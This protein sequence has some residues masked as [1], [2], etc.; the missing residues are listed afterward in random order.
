MKELMKMGF[1]SEQASDAL[2]AESGDL[3]A[4]IEYLF[5]NNT[6]IS[7]LPQN[8]DKNFVTELPTL[9]SKCFTSESE[10]VS[11]ICNFV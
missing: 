2:T 1:S 6:P 4:A 9:A 8:Y 3:E 7:F 11:Y 5:S 10:L